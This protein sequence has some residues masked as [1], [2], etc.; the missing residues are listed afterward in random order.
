MEVNN[1]RDF[2][3]LYPLNMQKHTDIG[4]M[5]S[6]KTISKFFDF[7]DKLLLDFKYNS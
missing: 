4:T 6:V 7:K 5:F 2:F 3:Y 1:Y